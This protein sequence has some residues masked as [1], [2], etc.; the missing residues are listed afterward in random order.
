MPFVAF[1]EKALPPDLCDA[2]VAR[3]E[4]ESPVAGADHVPDGAGRSNT[5][6]RNNERVIFDDVALAADLFART[7]DFLPPSVD[8]GTLVGYNERFRGYRYRDGQRSRRTST[9]PTAAR[10]AE[11]AAKAA[12]HRALLLERRLHRRRDRAHRLRVTIAPKKRLCALLR[13]RMLHEG[14][15]VTAEQVRPAQR[16]RRTGSPRASP[17][18]ISAICY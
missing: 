11:P 2:L 5:R 14:C 13:A 18:P 4:A 1:V 17:P 8:G 9:A 6:V 12:H 3:I 10:D 16:T 15:E 7:R